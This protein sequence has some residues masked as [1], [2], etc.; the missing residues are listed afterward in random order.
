MRVRSMGGSEDEG[1]IGVPKL[2]D[3]RA[4]GATGAAKRSCVAPSHLPELMTGVALV[5]AARLLGRP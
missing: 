5:L 4:F 3:I 2:L 1:R